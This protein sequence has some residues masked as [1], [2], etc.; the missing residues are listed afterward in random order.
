MQNN[1]P[2][3]AADYTIAFLEK[4]DFKDEKLMT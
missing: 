1:A 2:L 4:L 3:H